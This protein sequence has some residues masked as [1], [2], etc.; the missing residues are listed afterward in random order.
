[1][2]AQHPP[3]HLRREER[4]RRREQIRDARTVD[5]RADIWSIRACHLGCSLRCL[6]FPMR[7]RWRSATAT[8]TSPSTILTVKMPVEGAVPGAGGLFPV[9][10]IVTAATAASTTNQPKM[11]PAPFRGPCFDARIRMKIVSP[12][13]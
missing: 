12:T 7:R 5:P 3:Q 10:E 2:T 9:A 6:G 11:N 4:R 13:G 1:M 8:K